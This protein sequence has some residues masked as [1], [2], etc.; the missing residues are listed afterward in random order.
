MAKPNTRYQSYFMPQAYDVFKDGKGCTS[1]MST[2]GWSD[3]MPIEEVKRLE[4]K[5]D[6]WIKQTEAKGYVQSKDR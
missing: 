4:D 3:I 1:F 6:A 2:K 5:R